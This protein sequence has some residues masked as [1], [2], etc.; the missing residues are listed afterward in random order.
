MNYK[1]L[2]DLKFA[3]YTDDL[4]RIVAEILL[5]KGLHVALAK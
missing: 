2:D 4:A 3:G 5:K 1:I